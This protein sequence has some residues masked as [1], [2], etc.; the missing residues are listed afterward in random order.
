MIVTK[1]RLKELLGLSRKG[2][3]NEEEITELI[4]G[5]DIYGYSYRRFCERMLPD[6][7]WSWFHYDI[8]NKIQRALYSGRGGKL[9]LSIPPQ[10]GKTLL[11]ANLLI[12]YIFGMYPEKKTAYSTY[13]QPRAD[14][15]AA[16]VMEM[17]VSELYGEV[18]P[19]AKIRTNADETTTSA[20]KKSKKATRNQ[21][22]NVNSTRGEAKFIGVG[23][24]LT[25]FS[26]DILL[27]DDAYKDQGDAASD[28]TRTKKWHWF[29]SAFLT[30]QQGNSLLI[31]LSTRWHPDDI[32]GMLAYY[33]KHERHK[34]VRAWD[35]IE[36]PDMYD[37]GEEIPSY[38]PRGYG[39]PLWKKMI[40]V[41][42]EASVLD[43]DSY[44]AV[45]RQ[46]PPRSVGALFQKKHFQEYRIIPPYWDKV[47]IS[48]DTN[49]NSK[50]KKGDDCAFTVW[51]EYQRNLY[52][53]KFINKRFDFVQTCQ[54]LHQLIQEYP[55]YWA[56][57]IEAKANGQALIDLFQQQFSRII[58]F[59]P[60]SK[61]KRQRAEMALPLFYQGKVFVPSMA[62]C[63]NIHVYLEQMLSFTGQ[64]TNEK[65]DLVDST[66]QFM[67]Y[68][69]RM[70][71]IINVNGIAISTIKR[72][73]NISHS[74]G[75][76]ALPF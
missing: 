40:E 57:I 10:H 14:E 19:N 32:I 69:D 28:V 33:N 29:K 64:L 38:D 60:E 59:D 45:Y 62:L 68:I 51:G 17:I 31:V 23:G 71:R 13:S 25:G 22:G 46:R 37:E 52:L 58:A 1:E 48:I 65:D 75:K 39:E 7:D 70:L 5:L 16:A 35:V 43:R 34:M 73:G 76:V 67:I 26:G 61:S 4:S 55:N 47:I 15:T 11:C 18:F 2:T 36:Y 41:Y 30:R 21:F 72:A 56:V 50:S 8:I 12:P 54:T 63:Y 27:C 53:I 44:M 49:Y 3:I 6:F 20:K 24:S 42:L 66:I 9:T 74:R